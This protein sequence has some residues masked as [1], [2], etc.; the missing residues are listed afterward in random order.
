M[1][2]HGLEWLAGGE[3]LRTKDASLGAN[4]SVSVGVF[5]DSPE[6]TEP[7]PLPLPSDL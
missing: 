1:F 3:T 2:F 7:N 4:L 5:A 6:A